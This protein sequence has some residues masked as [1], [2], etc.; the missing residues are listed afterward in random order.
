MS[1]PEIEM[2]VRRGIA[3]RLRAELAKAEAKGKEQPIHDIGAR[4]AYVLGW[5]EG[6]VVA[7]IHDLEASV[8]PIPSTLCPHGTPMQWCRCDEDD[9]LATGSE[10]GP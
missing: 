10:E 7:L 1:A 3:A 6:A 8:I 5:L 4:Q 9:D 2:Y